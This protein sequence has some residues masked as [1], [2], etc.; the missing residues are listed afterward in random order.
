VRLLLLGSTGFIGTRFARIF[1]DAYEIVTEIDGQNP[2][3][4][5]LTSYETMVTYLDEFR[6][7]AILNLAGKSYHTAR[8]DAD[9]YESNVLVQLNL[10][11][12]IGD[13]KLNPRIVL[14]S[15]SAVYRSS[16]DPVEESSPC[17]PANTYAKAKYVQE[18]VGLSYR[19]RQ[20]VVVARLFNV[21][22]PHQSREFFIPAVIERL[23]KF[24]N[25][26]TE[27]VQ[28][29]T[30]NAMR[31]FIFVDDVC[32]ALHALIGRGTS[33]EIYNICS[34]RGVTVH[35][36][37]E[38]LKGVLDIA[39]VPLSPRDESV[40][41]GINYQAGSNRKMLELGWSPSYDI[42]KSFETIVREEYGT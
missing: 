9:M 10:H 4:V 14:C 19:P 31:D 15:S 3:F 1:S 13:L 38:V 33:G 16:T 42:R 21:I 12:A 24:R 36:V 20:H 32:G 18:R 6:P 35:E 30:L 2:E 28:L 11:E 26:E 7:H 22:G 25:G 17:L 41:E 39:T 40:K 34:G 8:D 29:K 5:D 23:M 37:I 27:E